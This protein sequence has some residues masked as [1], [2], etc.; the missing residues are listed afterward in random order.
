MQK[1][2]VFTANSLG[3]QLSTVTMQSEVTR[4]TVTELIV[5]SPGPTLISGHVSVNEYCVLACLGVD[6]VHIPA[7]LCVS[8]HLCIQCACLGR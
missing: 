2:S 5:L 4:W 8:I 6:N 1:S 7:S 3:I